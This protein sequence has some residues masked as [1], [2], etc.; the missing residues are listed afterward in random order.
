MA[1]RTARSAEE[2][3]GQIDLDALPGM[4]V[5]EQ[6]THYLLLRPARRFR[7]GAD[8]AALLGIAIVVALLICAAITPLVL[9]GL[10]AALLPA[11]PL[12]LDHRPDLALSAIEDEGST[13][14]TAHGQAA[15]DL[16]DFLDRYLGGLPPANGSGEIDE[17]APAGQDET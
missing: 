3:L 1:V 15:P 6:G 4:A 17:A 12:L 7:Y 16:A 5:A 10:P 13:R 8:L 11:V 9:A 14:V 2:V